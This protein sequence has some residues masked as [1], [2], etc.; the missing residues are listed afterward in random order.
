MTLLPK[1]TSSTTS[2]W[3]SS[4]FK[5]MIRLKT[6]EISKFSKLGK[7]SEGKKIHT[8]DWST[9]SRPIAESICGLIISITHPTCNFSRMKTE[10]VLVPNEGHN[11]I[12]Q[13]VH[14]S[15]NRIRQE[16]SCDLQG[17]TDEPDSAEQ[18]RKEDE[19][20]ARHDFW[21]VF[22]RFIHRHLVQERENVSATRITCPTQTC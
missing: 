20:E 5:L 14:G 4:Q 6:K 11:S 8:I 2:R 13:F 3:R 10:E 12:F 15:S 16:H 18:R 7:S 21:I 19:L 9:T 22:G 17:E 1:K